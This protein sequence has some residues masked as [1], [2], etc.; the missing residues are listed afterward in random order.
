[1]RGNPGVKTGM[2]LK[3]RHR[4]KHKEQLTF[5]QSSQC[6]LWPRG[7]SPWPLLL[8]PRISS[9]PFLLLLEHLTFLVHLLSLLPGSL[10]ELLLATFMLD[11]V[12]ATPSLVPAIPQIFHY[13]HKHLESSRKGY[14]I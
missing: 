8:A 6:H 3:D 1:M 4:P 7:P 2:E 5:Y 9:A 10:Q 11:M 12:P 14:S 13:T